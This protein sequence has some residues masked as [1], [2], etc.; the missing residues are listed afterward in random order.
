MRETLTAFYENFLLRAGAGGRPVAKDLIRKFKVKATPVPDSTALEAGAAVQNP[1][2]AAAPAAAGAGQQD[3]EP[4]T[5]LPKRRARSA[6]D[7]GGVD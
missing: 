4:A 1:P 7:R 3:E 5:T 2:A 6:P